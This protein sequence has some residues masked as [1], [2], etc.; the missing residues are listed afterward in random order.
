MA[1]GAPANVREHA[2]ATPRAALTLTCL[3]DQISLDIADNG[4]GFDPVG[5][6]APK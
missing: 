4:R 1:Q 2:A 3:G 6:P 5:P